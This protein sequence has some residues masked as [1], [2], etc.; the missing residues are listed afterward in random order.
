MVIFVIDRIETLWEKGKMLVTNIFSFSRNV[1]RSL[2]VGILWLWLSVNPNTAGYVNKTQAV[3]ENPKRYLLVD[4]S[5]EC[6]FCA[7]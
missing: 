4:Q 2:Q 3:G 6:S 5:S 7:V 1:S